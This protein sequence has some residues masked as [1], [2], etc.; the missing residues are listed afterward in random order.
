MHSDFGYYYSIQDF[1]HICINT[2]VLTE[3]KGLGIRWDAEKKIIKELHK[4]YVNNYKTNVTND[5]IILPCQ[6]FFFHWTYFDN[7][8][9]ILDLKDKNTPELQNLINLIDAYDYNNSNFNIRDNNAH[10][11]YFQEIKLSITIN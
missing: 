8:L 9:E 10:K 6:D 2:G 4:Q 7:I 5:F 1:I 11:N 3:R